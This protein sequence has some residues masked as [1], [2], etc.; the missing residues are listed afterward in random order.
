LKIVESGKPH[1]SAPAA[2][3]A[4]LF[5]GVLLAREGQRTL[6]GLG[7]LFMKINNQKYYKM[8]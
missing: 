5:F 3:T 1:S 8:L 6:P 7:H 2:G 4:P